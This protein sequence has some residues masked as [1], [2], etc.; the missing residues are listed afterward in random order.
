MFRV[1]QVCAALTVLFLSSTVWAQQQSLADVARREAERRKT[2]TTPGKV[3]TNDDVQ[4]PGPTGITAAAPATAKTAGVGAA[5]S[6]TPATPAPA[7]GAAAR[8]SD[9]GNDAV[10]DEGW[11]RKQM[12]EL[13]DQ[14]NRSKLFGDALQS[15][16]NALWADFTA[17]DDPAQRTL[18]EKNRLDALAELERVKKEIA[19]FEESIS[20]LEETARK[21]N[22]PPGWLR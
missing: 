17:R 20:E 5:G 9:T 18:I 2:V 6:P 11:W 21:A 16:I 10:R 19:Q 22:V 8:A 14:L 13:T 12:S 3:Y 15:R 4:R 1:P 7:V